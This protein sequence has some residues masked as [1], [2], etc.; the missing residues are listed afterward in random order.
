MRPAG[1]TIGS[2]FAA[3]PNALNFIRLLFALEVIVWH[4]Y[5]LRGGSWL[6][7]RLESFISDIAVDGFFVISG[8]LICHAWSRNPNLRRFA[9][10]RARRLLP[11]LWVCLVVTAFVIAPVATSVAGHADLSQRGQLEYVLGNATTWV[12][13]WGIDG[14]P[15][16]GT[17][18]AWNGSLWSLSW[19]VF[20]YAAV[21]ILGLCA[22]L[23]ASVV[24]WL[25]GVFW[26]WAFALV[27]SG[28]LVNSGQPAWLIPRLGLM[29]A[30][31]ALVYLLRDRIPMSRAL[32]ATALA[33]V[34]VGVVATPSYRLV[35]APAIAYLCL[36][37]GIELGR[38][39]RLVLRN[40]LSYGVYV[41]AFPIQQAL[42]MAGLGSIGWAAFA[43]L[44]VACT[45]P[46]AAASWFAVER[47]AQSLRRQ[48]F[49]GEP[50][51]FDRSIPQPLHEPH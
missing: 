4:S 39:P 15:V 6:P 1:K 7:E 35:A 27:V 16:G 32:A 42:L 26:L 40:D 49:R 41:Y 45:L 23:R 44:S 51:A 8:F 37:G 10:A 5:A 28:H 43:C 46:L 14:G 13:T 3:G 48:S 50:S 11:G 30:C 21:A 19:E 2:R 17:S 38:F 22:L 12:T 20:A 29:F 25:A 47:P 36:W 31:G 18:D 33:L 34:V 9:A 24:L